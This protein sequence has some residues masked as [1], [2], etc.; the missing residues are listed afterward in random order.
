MARIFTLAR[1]AGIFGQREQVFRHL[2]QFADELTRP[3]LPVFTE[4]FLQ[5]QQPLAP[6]SGTD[7]DMRAIV[8]GALE[9]LE[10]ARHHSS[11]YGWATPLPLLEHICRQPHCSPEMHRRRQL[12]RMRT[13]LQRAHEPHP[14][15][16]R[17]TVDNLNAWF[18]KTVC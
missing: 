3:E 8:T 1:L 16:V 5:P 6:S 18:W 10:R 12:V 2:A 9:T 4:P 7:H 17:E 15:L 13:G 14:L 11:F